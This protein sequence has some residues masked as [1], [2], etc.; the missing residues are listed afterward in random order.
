MYPVSSDFANKITS[1]DRTFSLRLT[2]GSSTVL[3]GTTIQDITLDEIVNSGDSLTM[4]CACSNKI[5]VNL[6]NP[7]MDI[8]YDG[9]SFTAEVGL[10]MK[11][12]PVTYEYVPLGKFYGAEPET[13]NDFK[14]LKLTAYSPLAVSI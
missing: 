8:E 4:G 3:T 6:I 12:R 1:N 2:F 7:P 9:A 11:E 13:N 5:T 10:L 14:N